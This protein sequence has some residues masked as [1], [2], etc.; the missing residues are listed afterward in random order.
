MSGKG[1]GFFGNRKSEF[2]IGRLFKFLLLVSGEGNRLSVHEILLSMV[3]ILVYT[4][5]A[6]LAPIF[7]HTVQDPTHFYLYI[8]N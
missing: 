2:Y 1:R 8:T 3:F 4:N 5:G 6:A 7:C